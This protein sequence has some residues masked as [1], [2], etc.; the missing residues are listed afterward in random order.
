[1]TE[2]FH[3]RQPFK[4]EE[5]DILIEYTDNEEFPLR[6][7]IAICRPKGLWK[8]TKFSFRQIVYAIR[9]YRTEYNFY[10]NQGAVNNAKDLLENA[11]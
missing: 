11:K 7:A 5:L 10:L 9:G 1:M 6:V 3:L 2:A 4:S 8:R